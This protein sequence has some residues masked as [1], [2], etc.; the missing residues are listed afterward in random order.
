MCFNNPLH[1]NTNEYHVT[2]VNSTRHAIVLFAAGLMAAAGI[3]AADLSPRRDLPQLGDLSPEDITQATIAFINVANTPG[4]DGM[5]LDV[6]PSGRRSDLT[7]ASLGF[8]AE[9]SLKEPVFEGYWG[10]A[11]GFGEL[12]D[13]IQFQG[14]DLDVIN[15]DVR[16]DVISLRGTAGLS[17]PINKHFKIVPYLSVIGSELES[18]S[19]ITGKVP[20]NLPPEFVVDTK[21]RALTGTTTVELAYNR[22]F[23]DYRLEY[24]G[25][26]TLAYTD[27]FDATAEL[28]ETSDWSQIAFA[29]FRVSGPLDYQTWGRPWRWNAYLS[30]TNFLDQEKEALGFSYYYEV[31]AG[32]D[33]EANIKPLDWFGI[34]LIGLRLGVIT[35]DDVDGFN[36][37]LTMR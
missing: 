11:L 6:D 35:G 14:D 4:L 30:H 24:S 23:D 15:L 26:Y 12:D 3:C 5:V 1:A 32:V 36:V 7:R 19:T 13:R 34:R 28:L 21:L 10:L 20:A 18:S 29:R 25:H 33:W 22:W 37:G 9:F 31:G 8:N 27:T 17:F 16:R 2:I